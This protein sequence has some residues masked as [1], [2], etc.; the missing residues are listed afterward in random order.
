MKT[1]YIFQGFLSSSKSIYNR[2]LIIATYAKIYGYSELNIKGFSNCDDVEYLR[3]SLT[4]FVDQHKNEK[5]LEFDLGHG[6]TSFRFFALLVSRFKGRYIIKAANRLLSRPQAEIV[7]ILKQMSV[8]AE[9]R[10]D[11]LY[12]E[13]NG[14]ASPT[15]GYLEVNT[16][17]S[18]Q[19]LSAILLNLWDLNFDLKIKLT[20]DQ[21]S[22]SY[23][24]M[25]LQ[26][27]RE[28]GMN[29]ESTQSGY[30]IAKL[31]KINSTNIQLEPDM[32]SVFSASAF[33]SLHGDI[34]I[35]NFT[36]QSIQPD[37]VFLEIFKNMGINF[38][39]N[40]NIFEI[41]IAEDI[42]SIDW[43]LKNCPDLFPV[44]AC[45][46]AFADGESILRGAPQLKS[47]ES[48]RITKI[49]EL[50][51]MLRID[52]E[53]FDDG[54]KIYG[55]SKR[56]RIKNLEKIDEKIIYLTDDD[57]RLAM[58]ASLFVPFVKKLEISK[59]E[60]V[61]KSCPEFWNVIFNNRKKHVRFLIGHRGVG[62]SSL[63]N[64][65]KFDKDSIFY[66]LDTEIEKRN[67]IIILNYLPIHGEESFR[68]LELKTI[69]L[70]IHE[71]INDSS[72]NV[73]NLSLG[74]G[75]RID[76]ILKYKAFIN[77]SALFIFVSR[78][79]DQE[80][81][82][83][84]NRPRLSHAINAI[85][86]S[87]ELY[88]KR[89]SRFLNHSN[90]NYKMIEGGESSEFVLMA[91]KLIFNDKLSFSEF[92]YDSQVNSGI[93][94]VTSDCI[95]DI[96]KWKFLIGL[97]NQFP[98]LKIEIRNDLISE[99]EVEFV[100]QNV[101]HKKVIY[102][103]RLKVTQTSFEQS[104]SNFD[105]FAV[106]WAFE[107]GP[108]P[109]EFNV[110][111]KTILI[112][113][114]HE[115][116]DEK[117]FFNYLPEFEQHCRN[118]KL[119]CHLKLSP[120]INSIQEL[121][122]WDQWRLENP[123][124]R[125]FL[126]RS[127]DKRWKWYRLINWNFQKINFLAFNQASAADQPSLIEALIYS[128][129]R[130]V[131]RQ[132]AGVLGCPINHSRSP[133]YHFDFF[134]RKETPFVGININQDEYQ[135][136]MQILIKMGLHYAAVTSPLKKSA[137]EICTHSSE[138][139]SRLN[140]VNTI[141]IDHL[142]KILGHNTDRDGFKEMIR[143]I[144]NKNLKIAIWGGGGTLQ[145][146]ISVINGNIRA[147]SAR[148]GLIRFTSELAVPELQWLPDVVIWAAAQ[149]DQ[150]KWPPKEWC[151]HSVYDLNYRDNSNGIEY[152]QLIKANYFSGLSMFEVQA[153][154][155]Q[156]FWSENVS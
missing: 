126:P 82:I 33:A 60:V 101:E 153:K 3:N 97:L 45:L 135:A 80:G 141:K 120:F 115:I 137:F 38:E 18:S 62:K 96:L 57:H 129:I 14:W 108:I 109:K 104:I 150:L 51:S 73:L 155:Q 70:L 43:N 142:G 144:N 58:A 130:S 26:M 10:A 156:K 16:S 139:A 123:I 105:F 133:S 140:S 149:G 110:N 145:M 25:T 6:G 85:D 52:H 31:Q 127:D 11:H 152:A 28:C 148:S 61:A 20:G 100:L 94:T 131:K 132:F 12:I 78:D 9:F 15:A 64:R 21:V 117:L 147:F 74:A 86:E 67:N 114:A 89:N 29:V 146:M 46:C 125:S 69:D 35:Y 53:C 116:S 22:E 17:Q 1:D 48:D 91:E 24:L 50:L 7:S 83:F 154:E 122:R 23:F 75:I 54:M 84:L 63:L 19:F 111:Q 92:F 103:F 39:I 13:S 77:F 81:R 66:D 119:N 68:E 65:L 121:Y 118:K 42:K 30:L 93:I 128:Q 55:H 112:L 4:Q 98:F 56:K 5:I 34:K 102:A 143:E 2:A 87:K 32:S 136:G 113:S 95:L 90:F 106:D 8:V 40:K 49:S 41:R 47:K 44:L 107:L 134:K 151:P 88:F 71:F 138:I 37:Y 99:Q 124:Q 36:E 79:S 27:C 72:S 59:S 76:K